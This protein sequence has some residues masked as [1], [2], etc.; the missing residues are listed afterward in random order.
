MKTTL[1]KRFGKRI[2][3]L[4]ESMGLTQEQLASKVGMDYKY[5]GSVERG[6]RN[7]TIDNIQRIAEAFGVETYQLF[8]FSLE[9]LKPQEEVIEEK[10]EDILERCDAEKK[11]LF[12]RIIAEIAKLE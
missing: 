10:I 12:L 4:R 11:Q 5:L 2:R 8:C 3:Q 7:I 6:E 9:G 1:K